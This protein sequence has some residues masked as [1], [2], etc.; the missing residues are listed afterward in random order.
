MKY[1]F[2]ML[3]RAH[4]GPS[5]PFKAY[6]LPPPG[7]AFFN[8]DLNHKEK[9]YE[10]DRYTVVKMMQQILQ[11]MYI[12]PDLL[13][14][15]NEEQK[16]IL[17]YK[18]REEQVRRWNERESRDPCPKVRKRSKSTDRATCIVQSLMSKDI[19]CYILS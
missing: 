17:F 9:D 14:E 16:Q 3:N 6:S 15:L 8:Q 13:H 1:F 10:R 7:E 2:P 4:S 19:T 12:E 5:L 11:D 18:I